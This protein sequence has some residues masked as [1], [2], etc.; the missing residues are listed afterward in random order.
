MKCRVGERGLHKLIIAHITTQEQFTHTCIFSI[1]ITQPRVT[2]V[3]I[4]I[5]ISAKC[6]KE[7]YCLPL[8]DKQSQLR[9]K[10]K[11]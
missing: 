2:L 4:T 3:L 10:R 6:Y 9:S 8:F 5:S 11:L 1:S 7:N